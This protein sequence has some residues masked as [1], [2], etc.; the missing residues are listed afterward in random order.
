MSGDASHQPDADARLLWELGDIFT[1][2]DAWEQACAEVERLIAAYAALKGTLARGP[3]ALLQALRVGDDLGQL[4]HR[5]YYYPALSHDT[6]QRDN[7]TGARRQQAQILIAKAAQAS[8]WFN[9]ELLTIPLEQVHAWLEQSEPLARY[10]FAL[11][12]VYRRQEHVLDEGGERLM[13]LGSRF[14]GALAEV[15]SALTV[16]DVAFP[17][18]TLSTGEEVTLT[19]GRYR[20]IL[21]SSRVQHDRAAAFHGLYGLYAASP[22]SYAALYNGVAQRDWFEAQARNYRSTLDAALHGDNIPPEVVHNLIAATREGTEPLRRYHRLRKQVLGVE[23]YHLYDG[24]CPLVETE[25]RYPYETVQG[26]IVESVAP[27]GEDYQQQMRDA[28]DG[29]WIDVYERDGK[30]SG[31]YSAP[32]YGVHP[33]ILLNYHDTLDDMFTLA[34]EMGHS[35]HTVLSH[36]HQ[37]FV[38]AGYSIFVA[39]VASTLN[40]ALLLDLLLDRTT[41]TTERVALL[42]HAIDAICGTFYTQVLFADWE[43][44]AHQLVEQGRPLTAE[45]LAA[46]YAEL[47]ERYY[48]DAVAADELYGMTWARI[49]HLFRSPYYVYQYATCFAASAK[50]RQDLR[51]GAPVQRFLD[52]LRAGGSDHPMDLLLGAGVD[53]SRPEPIRAVADQMSRRLDQ[54]EAELRAL[55][56]QLSR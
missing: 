27:L 7:A 19:H 1:D 39:E 35:M 50:I 30:R 36:R 20:A 15:Y 2:W 43:L 31:A 33:Y 5:V 8:S 14:R 38:Y 34:H 45:V 28:F 54:L 6:D 46:L 23:Q 4:A 29:R 42:Q 56:P 49:P 48:G 51:Q 52:L 16:A 32:V 13:A 22:N 37:P 18:V 24:T 26:W 47:L 17:T 25:A 55:G 12:E 40:E 21:A 11:E 44:Q 3:E 10:R 53:H 41:A 9:P